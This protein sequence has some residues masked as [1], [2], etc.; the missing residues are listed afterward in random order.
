MGPPPS[1][2]MPVLLVAGADAK[3]VAAAERMASLVPHATLEIVAD[4]GHTVHLERPEAFLAVLRQWLS[5][6]P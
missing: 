5:G 1:L 4:A 2:A 3:F 6:A